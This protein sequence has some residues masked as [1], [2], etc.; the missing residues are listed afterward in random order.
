MICIPMFIVAI[1]I[2]LYSQKDKDGFDMIWRYF[3]WSNQT[4]AVFTLW[5]LTVYLVQAKK[6]YVITLI[7]S[8]HDGGMFYLYFC[9]FR[10]G[11]VFPPVFLNFW[12][13]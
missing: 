1:G 10:K 5:A 8:I 2:L 11:L 9:S 13:Y 12:G 3:A 7:P 6:L 4:L